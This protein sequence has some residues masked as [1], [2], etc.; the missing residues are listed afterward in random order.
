MVREIKFRAGVLK[1][2]VDTRCYHLT[3]DGDRL[4]FNNDGDFIEQSEKLILMQYTGLK[5]KNGKEVYEG[6][7]LRCECDMMTLRTKKPT[8]KK[9]IINY[10]IIYVDCQARF[11]KTKIGSKEHDYFHLTQGS[12]TDWYEIIGNIHENPELL[13]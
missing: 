9:S 6:D 1:F 3:M 2:M 11:A 4:C 7:I 8:G 5:D 12:F 13:K 10:E